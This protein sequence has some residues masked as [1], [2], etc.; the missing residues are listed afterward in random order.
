MST[1]KKKQ[2]EMPI[3]PST[4][5]LTVTCKV[6]STVILGVV[7]LVGLALVVVVVGVVIV[8]MVIIALLASR[9]LWA[10]MTGFII[11]FADFLVKKNMYFIYI[12]PYIY[13][14]ASIP[15]CM[16]L[17]HMHPSP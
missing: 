4:E 14:Y 9:F 1:G 8:V 6:S 2:K 7:V 16:P 11:S 10:S 17:R 15:L 13:I 12:C 3:V 5:P